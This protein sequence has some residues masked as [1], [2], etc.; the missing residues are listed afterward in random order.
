MEVDAVLASF[1]A[2]FLERKALKAEEC[3]GMIVVYFCRHRSVL[4]SLE[5][6]L[7]CF[8]GREKVMLEDENAAKL[9]VLQACTAG[10]E[11]LCES[12]TYRYLG[13]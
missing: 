4:S 8:S 10:N 1:F 3:L 12:G 6:P 7:F 2:F 13:N 9:H 5:C 11:P